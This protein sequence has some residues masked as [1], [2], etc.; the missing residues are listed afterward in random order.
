MDFSIHSPAFENGAEIPKQYTG[1]GADDSPPLSWSNAPPG[2]KSFTLIVDDPDAPDPNSPKM[3]FTHW[4]LYNVPSDVNKLEPGL[5]PERLPPGTETGLN[6]FDEP[7]Y[8]G[9]NPPIGR[10]RYFFKLYALDGE[11]PN[12]GH[13]ATKDDVMNAMSGH[14]LAE[15]E[16][17]GTYRKN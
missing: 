6:D 7:G 12:L 17:F 4:V 13:R 10:H 15:T 16:T 2:T 3:V 9:P 5:T 8:N 1:L 14:V 11:L